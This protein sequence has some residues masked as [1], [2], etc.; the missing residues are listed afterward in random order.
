MQLEKYLRDSESHI[1]GLRKNWDEE[2][3]SRYK[4][5]TFQRVADFL[6]NLAAISKASTD[7][8]EKA[9]IIP[10]WSGALDLVWWS[11]EK[12]RFYLL[13]HFVEDGPVGYYGCNLD[14]ENLYEFQGEGIP[15]PKKTF[16]WLSSLEHFSTPSGV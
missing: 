7:L 5:K 9:R 1:L 14:K 11:P 12:E 6:K 8:A 15:D 4:R 3:A 2:G 13:M 10:S 16:E